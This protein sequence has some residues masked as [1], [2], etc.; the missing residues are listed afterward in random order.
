M[1]ADLLVGLQGHIE[2]VAVGELLLTRHKVALNKGQ[3]P[4]GI[5]VLATLVV[6]FGLARGIA[7]SGAL[8]AFRVLQALAVGLAGVRVHKDKADACHLLR[9]NHISSVVGVALRVLGGDDDSGG[10]AAQ[11]DGLAAADQVV[12]LIHRHGDHMGRPITEGGQLHVAQAHL[13]RGDIPGLQGLVLRVPQL[14]G[15][16][17]RAG[18]GGL[19]H[20]GGAVE[21]GQEANLGALLAVDR[22]HGEGAVTAGAGVDAVGGDIRVLRALHAGGAAGGQIHHLRDGCAGEAVILAAVGV[23]G[24]G[25][26]V[27][28]RRGLG[29]IIEGIAGILGGAAGLLP[30]QDMARVFRLRLQGNDLVQ[31]LDVAGEGVDLV[32]FG[33]Q[34]AAVEIHGFAGGVRQGLELAHHLHGDGDLNGV[35]LVRKDGRQICCLFV[36]QQHVVSDTVCL[37]DIVHS[38]APGQGAVV[39]TLD[40]L[41]AQGNLFIRINRFVVQ[42][43]LVAHVDGPADRL[44]DR[45]G[46]IHT[47]IEHIVV[48]ISFIAGIDRQLGVDVLEHR[49]DGDGAGI[50]FSLQS[51]ILGDVC[52]CFAPVDT[53]IVVQLIDGFRI[54]GEAEGAAGAVDCQEPMPSSIFI[55]RLKSYQPDILVGAVGTQTDGIQTL[56]SLFSGV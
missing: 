37:L 42:I 31:A 29:L 5:A 53:R 6:D 4:G 39:V 14:L 43:E 22:I 35:V 52:S 49:T 38:I 33:I 28:L 34:R 13:Y 44:G 23:H 36:H 46:V 11:G 41:I 7:G 24:E 50:G 26:H 25:Q 30:E 19:M 9:G 48:E 17:G 27:L 45:L 12:I 3:R 18:E 10:S 56:D 15:V 51:I 55:F 1:A 8:L 47:G 20:A 2:D 16:G 32:A 54:S 21:L 40:D